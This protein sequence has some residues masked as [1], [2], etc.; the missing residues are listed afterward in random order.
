[1]LHGGTLTNPPSKAGI[2]GFV[3]GLSQIASV[4][5]AT[6]RAAL[7]SGL[8]VTAAN[9]VWVYRQDTG[10]VEMTTNGTTWMPYAQTV[11]GVAVKTNG[12]QT[13][14]SSG[15]AIVLAA[16][17][18]VGGATFS[19]TNGGGVRVPRAGTYL[20]SAYANMSGGRTVDQQAFVELLRWRAGTS[21]AIA[22]TRYTF[23][24]AGSDETV[25]ITAPTTLAIDDIITMRVTAATA[26]TLAVWGDSGGTG[27][28]LSV[29]RLG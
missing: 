19:S 24:T 14:L 27:T 21:T 1:M 17:E 6:A 3:K 16:G 18:M 15:A 8:T 25:S 11:S 28:R 9:P 20:L 4:A 10:H 7:V 29:S 26:T 2:E 22:H 23:I 12:F 13:G 5:D